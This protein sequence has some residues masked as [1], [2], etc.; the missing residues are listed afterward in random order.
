MT[1]RWHASDRSPPRRSWLETWA[2]LH[3]LPLR[4]R[5]DAAF[6][7]MVGLMVAGVLL[8]CTVAVEAADRAGWLDNWILRPLAD[9][10]ILTNVRDRLNSNP[11][12][13]AVLHTPENAVYSAQAGGT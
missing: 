6:L 4:R 11:M 1:P 9:E 10:R 12:L 8:L 5:F 2:S 13:A 7:L 3:A